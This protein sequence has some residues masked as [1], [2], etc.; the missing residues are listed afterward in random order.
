[1][2]LVDTSVLVS[3]MRDRTNSNAERLLT[4][5]G[6]EE[7][8]LS[9]F[10]EAELLMGARDEADWSRLHAYVNAK[11]ILEPH[12]K[13]WEAAAR[14]YFDLRRD[15]RTVRKIVDCCIAQI[16]LENDVALIHNDRD[17][18]AIATMRSLRQVRLHMKEAK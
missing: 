9:R 8:C 18:E 5:I 2:M 14:I 11:P 17:F 15:G 7:L 1:M 13:T 4:V 16:A 6:S 10:S 3:V 12:P